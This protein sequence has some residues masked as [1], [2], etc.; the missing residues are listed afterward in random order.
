MLNEDQLR[1]IVPRMNAAKRSAFLPHLNAAMAE[2]GIDTLLRTA[3]FIA[4]L[5]HESGS[6]V[7]MK[8]LWGPTPAQRR[9]EPASSLAT[10]LGNRDPGDGKRYMGRGPIQITGRDNYRRFGELLGIDLVADPD[11]A[12]TPEVGFRIAALYWKSRDIN[13]AA[14]A[15]DFREVTRRING[16]F[17]GLADRTEFYERAKQVLAES[18]F[19]AEPATRGGRGTRRVLP[20]PSEP[21]SRGVETIAWAAKEPVAVKPVA[22]KTTA[23]K[24]PTKRP[25]PA[26]K[27]PSKRVAKKTLAKKTAAKKATAKKVVAKKAAAKKTPARKK[28][29]AKKKVAGK[30]TTAPRRAPSK[31]SVAAKKKPAPTSTA[32]RRR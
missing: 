19:V 25:T 2:G 1:R 3:A 8:E 21:L 22:K 32:R 16:G 9:Y 7:Y 12:A 10:R 24:T 4:Q 28:V 18:G 17:N 26:K 27:A 14:D 20:M 15:E 31:K 29:V 23:K 13:Q 5:A 6:F 30:T 11:S